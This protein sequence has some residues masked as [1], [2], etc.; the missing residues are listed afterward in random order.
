MRMSVTEL[1]DDGP[2]HLKS[3]SVLT[4]AEDTYLVLW[5]HKA[6]ISFVIILFP[7]TKEGRKEQQ[8]KSEK[9]KMIWDCS[10]LNT[11]H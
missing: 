10:E 1:N 9:I 4:V 3:E 6:P 8:V 2:N 5:K 7:Q 11:K